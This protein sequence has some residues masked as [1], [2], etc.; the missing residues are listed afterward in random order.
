M[1][2]GATILLSACNNSENI[3]KEVVDVRPP[4]EQRLGGLRVFYLTDKSAYCAGTGGSCLNDAVVLS[5]VHK[6][7]EIALAEF[8]KSVDTGT[9]S[10]YF[11]SS[12]WKYLIPALA[13][14]PKIVKKLQRG[15]NFVRIPGEKN[16]TF[17]V[18]SQLENTVLL[19]KLKT[20]KGKSVPE[21]DV[22]FKIIEK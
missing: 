15:S 17:Y 3:D 4:I 21:I 14:N 2:I 5:S 1:I 8:T 20:A 10:E 16:S 19:D 7:H 11:T 13:E 12:D 9:T 6:A 18:A 22:C